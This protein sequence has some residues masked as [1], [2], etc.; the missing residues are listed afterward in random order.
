MW[1]KGGENKNYSYLL[2]ISSDSWLHQ[3]ELSNLRSLGHGPSP[4]RYV[5]Q[6]YEDCPA[7]SNLKG[8]FVL[9]HF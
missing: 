8:M 2:I 6:S 1:D 9:D 3:G 7:C 5:I 4:L